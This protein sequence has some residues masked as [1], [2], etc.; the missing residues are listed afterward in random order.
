M[1]GHIQQKIASH[2]PQANHSKIIFIF[3]HKN[4]LAGKITKMDFM[5]VGQ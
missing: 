2:Y 5:E 4:L 3:F 1:I